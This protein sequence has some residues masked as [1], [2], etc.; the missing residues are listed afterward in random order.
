MDYLSQCRNSERWMF[1]RK[2]IVPITSLLIGF[3]VNDVISGSIV[4]VQVLHLQ[5]LAGHS[6]SFCVHGANNLFQLKVSN[7]LLKSLC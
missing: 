5:L 7:F 3:N 1:A 6:F 4:F 2:L